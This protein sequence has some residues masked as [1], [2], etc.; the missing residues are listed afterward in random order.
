MILVSSLGLVLSVGLSCL[1]SQTS[2]FITNLVCV[3]FCF[4]LL[5]FILFIF[6]K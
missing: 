3:S 1:T 5:N 4:I 6:K 2:L